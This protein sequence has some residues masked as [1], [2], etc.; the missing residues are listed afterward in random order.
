MQERQG[1]GAWGEERRGGRGRRQRVG[2]WGWLWRWGRRGWGRRLWLI[3]IE[4]P[5]VALSE[6]CFRMGLWV[7]ESLWYDCP[8]H[9]QAMSSIVKPDLMLSIQSSWTTRS[10][11]RARAGSSST[12]HS[13]NWDCILKGQAHW[14]KP[15]CLKSFSQLLYWW[16]DSLCVSIRTL[17]LSPPMAALQVSS[18]WHDFLSI[19]EA[20]GSILADCADGTRRK[21]TK[22]SGS[23][24]IS[25]NVMKRAQPSRFSEAKD[26]LLVPQAAAGHMGEG[27]WVCEMCRI[28]VSKPTALR[29]PGYAWAMMHQVDLDGHQWG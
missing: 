17:Y 10:K 1:R 20:Q 28:P 26:D 24:G 22:W 29:S 9:S 16:A 4:S 15:P 12:S 25:A 21:A 14:W 23:S 8:L 18:S 3:T 6:A 2:R 13:S 11:A 5:S 27:A 19:R 7:W